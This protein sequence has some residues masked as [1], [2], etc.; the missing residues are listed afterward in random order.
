MEINSIKMISF[1]NHEKTN[2][3][4]DSGT[5]V[6]WGKNGSGKTSILEAIHGLS[7]GK[8][9][10]TNNKKELI[11]RGSSGFFLQGVFRNENNNKNTV[12]FSQDILGNKKIKINEKEITKRKEMLG[13]NNVVV[14]SP[15][16]EE[17]TK[18]PAGERRKYFNRLFSVCSKT[19]LENLLSYNKT[20][21]QRNALLKTKNRGKGFLSIWNERLSFFG[22]NLWVERNNKVEEIRRLFKKTVK[23]F[24]SEL[25]LD[26]Q[27]KAKIK[28]K[29]EIIKELNKNKEVDIKRGLTS[30]GP[31][32]D[33]ILF[34]W[35]NK[36][37]RKHG[38]QGEHKLFL[39]LLKIVEY[40]YISKKTKTTPFF[41]ID[42]MFA[43]LDK[44]RSKNIIRFIEGLHG[45][46]TRSPQII[47][48]TTDIVDIEKNKFFS[49]ENSIKKHKIKQNGNS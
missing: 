34:F 43:S 44:E 19:Y 2:I 4:F 6:I 29:K 25:D 45:T 8:S 18:G 20:L 17:V 40:A 22:G 23:A 28:N 48:T 31:H 27:H 26:I 12:S 7:V 42:D 41:L 33:E 49:G 32:K 10:K 37:I 14:F 1:R 35:E 38:S 39:A 3:S 9:F 21:K 15:E 30:I 13:L 36:I 16:E 11:K 47:I 46:G 24:D 5:T